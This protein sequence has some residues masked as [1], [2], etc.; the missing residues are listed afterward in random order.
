ME[1]GL[2]VPDFTVPGGTA[3]LGEEL[4]GAVRAGDDAGF[5]YL[6]VMDHFFQIP[7]VGPSDRP[8]LE[9][10][11]TLGYFAAHTQRAKLFTYVTGAIYRHPGLLAKAVTTLDVLSGGRA[12]LGIGAGWNEEEARGLGF[13]FPSRTERF[14]L[15]EENLR[16]VRQM[17]D[18]EDKP[19]SGKH[20][21]AER[22]L[23]SPQP[24]PPP[25]IMVGGGGEK[26]TLRLVAKYGDF[27]NIG[28]GPDLGHKLDVLKRHCE[29]E[30]R[31]YAEITKT[32][33]HYLDIG[34]SGE[35]TGEFLAEAR[36]LY[37]LGIQ[38]VIGPLPG[39]LDRKK[40]EIFAQDIIPAVKELA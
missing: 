15:L 38:A 39:G 8:M 19:F 22:L 4:A 32:V 34:P 24:L 26:K 18:E 31:D 16:Y 40:I 35:K 29:T 37:R 23:N 36:R 13:P 11:T 20:F 9:A 17:W 30:G 25:P 3:A 7:S 28:N 12:M 21:T 27:C 5:A 33:Y 10:Y 1:L 14:E 2:Q 6:A